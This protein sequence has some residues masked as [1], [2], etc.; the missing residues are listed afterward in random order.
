MI[1]NF[2]EVAKE[3]YIVARGRVEVQVPSGGGVIRETGAVIGE[4][5]IVEPGSLHLNIELAR[6][7][8]TMKAAS[9]VTLFNI[10]YTAVSETALHNA[11]V[12]DTFKSFY[13]ERQKEN[14]LNCI[15]FFNSLHEEQRMILQSLGRLYGIA[16]SDKSEDINLKSPAVIVCCTGQGRLKK[17]EST[18]LLFGSDL[19]MQAA[20]IGVKDEIIERK[21]TLEGNGPCE[22]VVWE[23]VEFCQWLIRQGISTLD[24]DVPNWCVE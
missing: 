1:C 22:F 4:M 11:K 12:E 18:Q 21:V 3:L 13:C 23:G 7:T 2:R 15:P 20:W 6:R 19:N 14:L 24:S 9:E 8:A 17:E 5:A 16:S 10:P